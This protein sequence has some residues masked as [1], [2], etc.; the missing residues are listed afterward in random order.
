MLGDTAGEHPQRIHLPEAD[1]QTRC[2]R[3]KAQHVHAGARF[4]IGGEIP[5]RAA[6]RDALQ[7]R[8]HPRR[9]R[10]IVGRRAEQG[11]KE[12]LG[13]ARLLSIGCLGP[14]HHR[15]VAYLQA[16][17][18]MFAPAQQIVQRRGVGKGRSFRHGRIGA[19]IVLVSF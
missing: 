12:I 13:G 14:E 7:H 5:H 9:L 15:G 2:I 1:R 3:R 18:V 8:A 10:C 11:G 6:F 16:L 17:A 19:C 4:E